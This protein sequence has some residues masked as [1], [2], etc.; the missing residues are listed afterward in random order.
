LLNPGFEPLLFALL[1][2]ADFETL[3][4]PSFVPPYRRFE[5]NDFNLEFLDDNEFELI[6]ERELLGCVPDWPACYRKCFNALTPGGWIDIVEPGT[7][8]YY[9]AVNNDK[10]MDEVAGKD[11]P[12]G[13][14][15]RLF[16]EAAE[17]AGMDGNIT[18]KLKG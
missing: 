8:D 2:R 7:Q 11:H 6:H 16:S 4:Q 14:F 15:S 9:S 10:V 5:V 17:K 18:P 13:K 3:V 1:I 12:L